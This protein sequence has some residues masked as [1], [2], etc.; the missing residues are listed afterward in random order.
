MRRVL[1]LLM[2]L[3]LTLRGLL[4][5]AMAMGTLPQAVPHMSAAS[6]VQPHADSHTN[7]QAD[8]QRLAASPAGDVHSMGSSQHAAAAADM[9]PGTEHCATTTP[10]APGCAGS[11]HSTPCAAC[12]ICHSV[13]SSPAAVAPA[14]ALPAHATPASAQARF[15]SAAL[16]QAIK[17]PIA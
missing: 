10:S 5:D 15:A 8:H 6:A 1:P 17:P 13:L 16:L 7:S 12:G 2:I 9:L 14:H 4:G 11:H 3:L